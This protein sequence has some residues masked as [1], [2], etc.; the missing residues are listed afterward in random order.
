M[1]YVLVFFEHRFKLKLKVFVN[2]LSSINLFIFHITVKIIF[3]IIIFIFI[4]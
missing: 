3:E 1:W 2:E 4:S